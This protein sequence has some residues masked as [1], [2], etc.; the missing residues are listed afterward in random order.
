MALEQLFSEFTTKVRGFYETRALSDVALYQLFPES[1]P[2]VRNFYAK[3]KDP[4]AFG[5]VC[6]GV[7][8]TKEGV[9]CSVTLFKNDCPDTKISYMISL[10]GVFEFVD[11]WDGVETRQVVVGRGE[12]SITHDCLEY[13]TEIIGKVRNEISVVLD[14][15]IAD[16]ANGAIVHPRYREIIER[17]KEKYRKRKDLRCKSCSRPTHT[18]LD[19]GCRLCICCLVPSTHGPESKDRCRFCRKKGFPGSIFVEY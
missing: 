17:D 19:C 16:T 8:P 12:W 5:I 3:D 9:A 6:S 2:L 18:T 7:V 14:T 15:W 13:A 4:E 11:E 10:C 1:A